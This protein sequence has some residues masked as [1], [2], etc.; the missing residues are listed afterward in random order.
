MRVTYDLLPRLQTCRGESNG[1][2][3][4]GVTE[5][6]QFDGG[7]TVNFPLSELSREDVVPVDGEL[8]LP[9]SATHVA[10]WFQQTN[11]WGCSAYDSDYGANHGFAL[12]PSGA[13]A[14]IDFTSDVSAAPTETGALAAGDEVVVHYDP[15]RLAQCYALSNE[16][17][18]WGVTLYWQIDG[19]AV[20]STPASICRAASRHAG[21]SF[22]SA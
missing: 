16:Q 4:W 7:T 13:Q 3:V 22:D 5:F 15:D 2:Q 18:A 9:A 17:P 10:L 12:E 6:A 21:C 20:S 14:V 11:E 1:F 8:A 19:G